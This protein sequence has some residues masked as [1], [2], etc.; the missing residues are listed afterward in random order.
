MFYIRGGGHS[1]YTNYIFHLVLLYIYI[2]K[3]DTYIVLLGMMKVFSAILNEI[4]IS[5]L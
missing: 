3:L 4:K 5:V 2:Q 1:N